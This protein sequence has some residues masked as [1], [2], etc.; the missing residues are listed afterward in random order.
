MIVHQVKKCPGCKQ[1]KV[2]T[3]CTGCCEV[4]EA[5]GDGLALGGS[6]ELLKMRYFC[7]D[8]EPQSSEFK[9]LSEQG[10]E[11]YQVEVCHTGIFL[12]PSLLQ[13]A[14]LSPHHTKV[15]CLSQEPAQPHSSV[16]TGAP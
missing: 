7:S 14:P 3:Q 12:H 10:L 8:I 15:Q 11:K 13:G 9:L 6:V 5:Q 2:G 16:G 4:S 1:G